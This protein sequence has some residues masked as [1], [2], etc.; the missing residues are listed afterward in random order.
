MQPEKR[1][2]IKQIIVGLILLA[3]ALIGLE[4]AHA[5]RFHMVSTNPPIKAVATTSPSFNVNFSKPLSQ[6]SGVTVSPDILGASTVS[7]K[8]LT[9]TFKTALSA[10][11]S[12][13]ITIKSITATN[14]SKLANLKLTFKPKDIP[15]NQL[16]P[17]QQKEIT[18]NQDKSQPT[19]SRDPILSHLPYNTINYTLSADI[20]VQGKQSTLTLDAQILLS[21]ADRANESAAV[22]GYKQ[23]IADYI[24]SLGLDPTKY[25]ITYDV[26]SP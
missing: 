15:Y 24:T 16:S 12:Y 6:V 18:N 5:L 22:A 1:P 10:G 11:T 26:V 8:K 17:S 9:I 2:P 7:G 20:S 21:S 3:V 14:G 13:T 4:A 25:T 23:Q 19:A